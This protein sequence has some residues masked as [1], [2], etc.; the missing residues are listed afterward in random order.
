MG[1][2]YGGKIMHGVMKTN[3]INIGET[4]TGKI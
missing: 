1:E 2:K 4:E 3:G